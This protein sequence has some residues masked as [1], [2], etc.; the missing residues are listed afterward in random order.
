MFLVVKVLYRNVGHPK[1]SAFAKTRS[2]LN[3]SGE[4]LL[5]PQG[6]AEFKGGAHHY[7]NSIEEVKLAIV[8]WRLLM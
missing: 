1:L 8:S 4:H 7:V 3:M 2:W 6:E 5:F